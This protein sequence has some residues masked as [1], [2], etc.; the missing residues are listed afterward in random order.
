MLSTMKDEFVKEI[1]TKDY[2]QRETGIVLLH[3]H[4]NPI[5]LYTRPSFTWDAKLELTTKLSSIFNGRGSN[6]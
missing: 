4:I 3:V 1:I 6:Q 5:N 2:L